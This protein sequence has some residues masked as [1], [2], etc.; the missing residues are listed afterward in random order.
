MAFNDGMCILF[1]A[2]KDVQQ[3]IGCTQNSTN[4]APFNAQC[5]GK[6][7]RLESVGSIAPRED[8]I[9]EEAQGK[10]Q[11]TGGCAHCL[12]TMRHID[13]C[14]EYDSVC[15][16][17]QYDME[18]YYEYKTRV[19]GRAPPPG[20]HANSCE[21]IAAN[22]PGWCTWDWGR[23]G[24]WGGSGQW[25]PVS[26]VCPQCGYYASNGKKSG[27]PPIPWEGEHWKGDPHNDYYEYY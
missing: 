23:P 13:A 25:L 1:E 26:Q 18:L 2:I 7:S 16:G 9:M 14:Y 11:G 4:P 22:N 5:M 6:L 3:F 27:D 10:R 21:R 24:F 20:D 17:N 8:R 12:D 15:I 19:D